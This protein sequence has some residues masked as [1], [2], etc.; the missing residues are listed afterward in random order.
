M[1]HNLWN[2]E[3]YGEYTSFEDHLEKAQPEMVVW[4]WG[5]EYLAVGWQNSDILNASGGDSGQPPGKQ[6]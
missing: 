5:S 2:V 1:K 3:N 6:P 4:W